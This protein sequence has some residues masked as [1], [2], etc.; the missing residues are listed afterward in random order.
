MKSIVAIFVMCGLAFSLQAQRFGTPAQDPA[1][2]S[3]PTIEINGQTWLA[4]NLDFQTSDAKC[5]HDE[6]A[7]CQIFGRLYNWSLAKETCARLGSGWRL[8]SDEDWVAMLSY[9]SHSSYPST[10]DGKKAYQEL[11]LDDANSQ[12]FVLLG[13]GHT[14]S[15]ATYTN[16]AIFWSATGGQNYVS[17]VFFTGG[18]EQ[19]VDHYTD[20]NAKERFSVRCVKD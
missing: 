10:F 1:G 16:S 4:K 5:L 7:N 12:L 14:S 11:I 19:V 13:G 9:V 6:D 20:I 15:G 3:Y 2:K 8:P 18:A 17:A